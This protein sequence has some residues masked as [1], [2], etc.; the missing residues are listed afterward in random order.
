MKIEFKEKTFEKY[1]GHELARLTNTTYSPDQCD[2]KFLGF[3][4]AYLLPE[5]WFFRIAPYVRRRP[6]ARMQGIGVNDLNHI[7][8]ELSRYLPKF[9]F[10]LFVQ[11]KRPAYLISPGAGQWK[12]WKQS[13]YRYEITPHQQEALE[14]IESQSH[15]RA[16]TVYASPAFWRSDDLWEHVKNEAVV[17]NSNMASAG[18]LSG[19]GH[20]SY[21]SAGF[22]GK[23]H[24]ETVSIDS[25]PLRQVIKS[26]LEQNEPLPLNQHLKKAA[27]A[28]WEATDSGDLAAPIFHRARE[29]LGLEEIDRNSLESAMAVIDAFSDAF[30]VRYYAMG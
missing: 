28:I 17:D 24:S 22:T 13:Y 4:E 30:G 14:K 25:E 9:R 27:T 21:V 8:E 19:H 18:R 12:D 20:Y 7:V 10:N 16:A 11:F 5:E 6:R 2:E 15:G 3:D 23:G 26:G 1:Y 29:A